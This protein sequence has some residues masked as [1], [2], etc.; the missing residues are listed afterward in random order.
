VPKD[1]QFIYDKPNAFGL[2][3]NSHGALLLEPLSKKDVSKVSNTIMAKS[4]KNNPG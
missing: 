2:A 1:Y 3:R 4:A